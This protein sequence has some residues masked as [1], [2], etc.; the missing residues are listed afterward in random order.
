MYV[1]VLCIYV[2]IPCSSLETTK[3]RL[4]N[5]TQEKEQLGKRVRELEMEVKRLKQEL[6]DEQDRSAITGDVSDPPNVLYCV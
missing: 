6:S 2:Y 1:C 3:A 4:E 5:E